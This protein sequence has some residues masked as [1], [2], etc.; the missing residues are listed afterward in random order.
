MASVRIT[1]DTRA[2][3][4]DGTFPLKIVVSHHGLTAQ[5]SLGISVRRDEWDANRRQIVGAN[6]SFLNQVIGQ[7]L[8]DWQRAILT[9]APTGAFK[10]KTAIAVRDIIRQHLSP[11]DDA[12]PTFGDWYARFTDAHENT[13]TREIYRATWV[14][15]ERYDRHAHTRTFEEITKSWLDGFFRWCATTSPSINARNIHLRNIRAVFND[16]IDNEITAAYPFRRFRITPVETAKR[17]LTPDELRTIFTADT[18]D[19]QR[20]YFDAFRLSFL[21]IGINI[22]DLCTLRPDNYHDGRITYHR[23]KTHKLYS[24]K[25]EPEA[26]EIINRNRGASLLLSWAENRTSYRKFADKV[27]HNLPDRVTTYY[28]RHSWATIAALLDIPDDTISQALGHSPRN[29]T[30]AIYIKRDTR[31]VDAANRRVIDFVLYG[32]ID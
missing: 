17:A 30:T 1:L 19:W 2:R 8:T 14:Q 6:K 28:A 23:R 5:H 18:P 15:V 31:K 22:A 24:V 13:R 25:V 32:K 9:L 4:L 7:H 3:K 12:Q 10:N 20:R 11:D 16:A 26:A 29:A 21:L 27:N